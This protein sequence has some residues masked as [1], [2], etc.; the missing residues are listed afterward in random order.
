MLKTLKNPDSSKIIIEGINI[1]KKDLR[2]FKHAKIRLISQ[3]LNL[4]VKKNVK[5]A[6][7]RINLS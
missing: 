1:T 3:L 4:I 7:I 5:M 6:H 2:D